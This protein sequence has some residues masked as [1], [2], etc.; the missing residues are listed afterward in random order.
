VLRL[1]INASVPSKF[2]GHA[3]NVKET[4]MKDLKIDLQDIKNNIKSLSK[5][6]H[7]FKN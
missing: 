6:H 1:N 3:H 7:I 2:K 5:Q 4:K